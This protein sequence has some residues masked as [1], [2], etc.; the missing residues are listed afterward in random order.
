MAL[1]DRSRMG[2]PFLVGAVVVVLVFGALY[3]AIR[4]SGGS[5]STVQKP[6]P[7]GAVEQAYVAEITFENLNMSSFENMLHQKV[8]YLDGD[9]SNKGSRTIRAAEV[10]VEFYDQQN[11]LALRDTRRIIG[12]NT[13]PLESGETQDFRIGFEVIPDTWNHKFPSIRITGLGL[14]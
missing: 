10:T 3:L 9:I 8:T 7:F 11:K 13:Q 1:D 6:L 4:F 5:T 12:D 14:E 2:G